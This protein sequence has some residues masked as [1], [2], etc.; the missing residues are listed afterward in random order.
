MIYDTEYL[1]F[2]TQMLYLG[3]TDNVINIA[4]K[5]S[6]ITLIFPTVLQLQGKQGERNVYGWIPTNSF[7]SF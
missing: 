3:R 7:L 6:T 2:F 1:L 4:S 5:V